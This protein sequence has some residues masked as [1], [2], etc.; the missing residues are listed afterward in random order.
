MKL[1][2]LRIRNFR[3]LRDINLKE[4][5]DANVLVGKNSSGKSNLLEALHMFFSEFAVVGGTTTGLNQYFWYNKQTKKP[6]EFTVHIQLTES[7]IK[8]IFPEEII[9]S[10]KDYYLRRITLRIRRKIINIQGAWETELLQWWDISL[11]KD[12]KQS[13]PA[14]VTKQLRSLSRTKP[15]SEISITPEMLSRINKG[16]EGQI[17]GKFKLVS[18]IRDVRSPLTYRM[19]VLDPQ[20]QSSLWTLDQ[21]TDDPDEQIYSEIETTFRRI[22]GK[23]LDPAHGEIFIRRKARRFPLSLEGGG[24]QA[25]MKMIFVLKR[26]LQK[27]YVL[28]V[29]EPEAHSHPELQ[30][31]VFDELK[32]L[33]SVG[34]I[35][36]TTHSPTFIDRAD[37]STTWIVKFFN[38]QTSIRRISEL[39]EVIEE[40][41]IRPSD[42][43]FFANRILFVEG[44][45]EEVVIPVFA[46]KLDI[47]LKD[48]AII[49]VE[50]KNKARL[51][52]E[53]W[54]RT[55]RNMCPLFLLLDKDAEEEVKELKKKKLIETGRYHVW[56]KGSIESYYPLDIL[57]DALNEL[58][59][60]YSLDM[61]VDAI[62][63]QIKEGTLSPDRIDLGEKSKLLDRSWE[64]ILGE[65]VARLVE[66]KKVRIPDEVQR[67]LELA[68]T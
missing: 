26:E 33:S 46:K 4:V 16:I 22:T 57:S 31:K 3:S 56:Q 49:P 30:R 64:V 66:T 34:Q 17:K 45:T 15:T 11:V 62:M 21:S 10:V 5:G 27:G 28:G 32:S 6:I 53:T 63:K 18:Q 12:N 48:V 39:K 13:T 44:K 14:Q 24:V 37:L 42:I 40:L 35:F 47:D 61:N 68:V 25:T 59:S 55:T 23:R 8:N 51:H 58:N 2:Y 50:G 19:T 52:L 65:S 38:G 54:M 1:S 20:L 36:I 43:L 67:A 60:R 41:G 29:E 9:E 7:E